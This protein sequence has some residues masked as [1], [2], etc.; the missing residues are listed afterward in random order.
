MQFKGRTAQSIVFSLEFAPAIDHPSPKRLCVPLDSV[1]CMSWRAESAFWGARRFAPAIDQIIRS[2]PA[3]VRVEELVRTAASRAR[4][5]R[6]HVWVEWTGLMVSLVPRLGSLV[7]CPHGSP[8]TVQIDLIIDQ[9]CSLYIHAA[10]AARCLH[11]SKV[12]QSSLLAC[13]FSLFLLRQAS[14]S[15]EASA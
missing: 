4:L 5:K 3:Y 15:C 14:L 7:D 1:F 2:Y 6:R 11:C 8:L 10:A 9:L 12:S 13:L